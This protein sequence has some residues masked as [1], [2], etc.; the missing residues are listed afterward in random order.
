[1][2]EGNIGAGKTSLVKK[3]CS[4]LGANPVLEQFEDN[5]F[6]P[7]FYENPERY[8]FP[9]ELSFL[10]D[11]YKQHREELADRNMFVPLNVADYYF[12]KSLIFAGITLKEDEYRLYRKLYNIIHQNLPRPDLYVYLH[13]SVGRLR[14]NIQKRGREYEKE[15]SEGYLKKLQE[16]Y[17]NYFRTEKKIKILI[18][19]VNN[20]NFIT[21]LNDYI[22]VKNY[23][24]E[25]EYNFGITRIPGDD[26][27]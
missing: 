1:V 3:L 22:S 5:P 7:K 16:G 2:I 11:R 6:L 19:D 26:L 24:F 20:L 15:I 13:A 23:I 10:A 12:S 4:D 25:Q 21:S 17:F 8:S 14:E 27:K 18:I 9:L